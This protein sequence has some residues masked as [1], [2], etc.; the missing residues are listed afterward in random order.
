MNSSVSFLILYQRRHIKKPADAAGS[1]AHN[2]DPLVNVDAKVVLS[3]GL[4]PHIG[5]LAVERRFRDYLSLI[6]RLS[7]R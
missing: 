6:F 1:S 4:S 2:A 3:Y 7:P 5:G